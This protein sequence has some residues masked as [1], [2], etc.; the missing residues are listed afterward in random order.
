MIQT[1]CIFAA[2]SI[3]F[4]VLAVSAFLERE[5]VDIIRRLNEI[6]SRGEEIVIDIRDAELQKSFTERVIRPLLGKAT[7]TF[8]KLLP[9]SI[10]EE[11][12]PKLNQ[13]GNPGGLVAGEYLTIKVLCII[14]V[15]LL[16]IPLFNKLSFY[17]MVAVVAGVVLGLWILPDYYLIRLARNRG[18]E[19]ERSMPD[20]LD[21]LTVSI[22]AGYGWDAALMKVTEKRKG[23]LA[24]EFRQVAQE[25]KMGKPRRKA[26]RDLATRVNVD[27]L[28]TFTTAIIQA[29]Q[30]GLRLGDVL[31]TQSELI[32][33]KRRQEIEEEAMKAPI[34]MLVPMLIF[35]FPVIFIVLLGPAVVQMLKVL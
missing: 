34:K 29:D 1:S 25:V 6:S 7:K 18:L 22:E 8:N 19:I 27:S 28:T 31:R 10:I 13:A 4:A 23:A 17:Q 5:E 15:S 35:I 33:H 14:V 3:F 21:L 26:L 2:M 9:T 24:R 11:L 20:V 12:Q 16:G 32:R 30:L